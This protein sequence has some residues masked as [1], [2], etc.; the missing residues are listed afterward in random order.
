MT[1]HES[2][3]VGAALVESKLRGMEAG[4]FEID[5]GYYAADSG[6]VGCWLGC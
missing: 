5:G 6:E 3:R 1:V 4:R 2:S